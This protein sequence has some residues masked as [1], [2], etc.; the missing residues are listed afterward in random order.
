MSRKTNLLKLFSENTE[1]HFH[2]ISNELGHLIYVSQ[3]KNKYDVEGLEFKLNT[4]IEGFLDKPKDTNFEKVAPSIYFTDET[5]SEK[6]KY[7]LSEDMNENSVFSSFIE[8]IKNEYRSL[9]IEDFLLYKKDPEAYEKNKEEEHKQ[10]QLET[11]ERY[12]KQEEEQDRIKRTAIEQ[13]DENL[14]KLFKENLLHEIIKK[15]KKFK[16]KNTFSQLVYSILTDD[17]EQSKLWPMRNNQSIVGNDKF[18]MIE[19]EGSSMKIL[20]SDRMSDTYT[21][22]FELSG[23]NLNINKV[24]K[25]N[26]DAKHM[27]DYDF[28]MKI[29]DFDITLTFIDWENM[30]EY[31]KLGVVIDEIIKLDK[32]EQEKKDKEKTQVIDSSKAKAFF[33]I[34][35]YEVQIGTIP[36]IIG[37]NISDELF[38]IVEDKVKELNIDFK[39]GDHLRNNIEFI[40]TITSKQVEKIYKHL[41]KNNYMLDTYIQEDEYSFMDLRKPNISQYKIYVGWEDSEEQY[42]DSEDGYHD[43]EF[44]FNIYTSHITSE[45]YDQEVRW[46]DNRIRELLKHLNV[47]DFY[48]DFGSAENLHSVSVK[49][50]SK[51]NLKKKVNNFINQIKNVVDNE[52]RF[53]WYDEK[54]TQQL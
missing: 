6:L 5:N 54:P 7:D 36:G 19:I 40:D 37:E 53:E 21:I 4:I 23:P 3:E 30:Y 42:Y 32:E 18:N 25:V 16:L 43:D 35:K 2:I 39:R 13:Y 28:L 49:N 20:I 51:G 17:E 24:N 31:E 45:V 52:D 12:K 48:I 47:G 9:E 38:K 15:D 34:N 50:A 26:K 46:I 22:K 29:Y 10:Q 8:D 1:Y 41:I 33:K 44:N 11:W 27:S 14:V